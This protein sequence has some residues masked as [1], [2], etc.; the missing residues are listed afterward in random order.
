MKEKVRV[1]VVMLYDKIDLVSV[2]NTFNIHDYEKW[3]SSLHLECEAVNGL[4]KYQIQGAH[5]YIYKIGCVAFIGLTESEERDLL[6]KVRMLLPTDELKIE[7]AYSEYALSE[8][9]YAH[10]QAEAMVRSVRLKWIEGRMN[11][12]GEEAEK[13]L[14]KINRGSGLGYSG[15]LYKFISKLQR[16]EIESAGL[17][18]L[19]GRPYSGAE[20]EAYTHAVETYALQERL[21]VL[22]EK[23]EMFRG[24]T[25]T[26]EV[27]GRFVG[28]QRLLVI[29]AILLVLFPLSGVLDWDL[30]SLW[31]ILSTAIES[32]IH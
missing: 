25:D 23:I 20:K 14:A 3:K 7:E 11:Q 32:F 27:F 29:E 24:I 18:A 8:K 12:L 6:A 1:S 9:E 22:N 13:I 30:G 17:L 16:F 28:W 2:A 15:T 26:H 4:L 5:I 10:T 19:L 31:Q 21:S